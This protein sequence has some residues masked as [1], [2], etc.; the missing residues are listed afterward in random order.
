MTST[1]TPRERLKLTL[2]HQQPDRPPRRIVMTPEVRE[3]LED[4]FDERLGTRDVLAV[5]DVDFREVMPTPDRDRLRQH[6]AMRRCGPAADGFYQ[7]TH[8]RPL[9]HIQTL[10]DVEAYLPIRTPDWYD[11]SGIGETCRRFQAEG[12][13]AVFGNAGITDIVNG[14][15]ARGRGYEQLICEIMAEDAVAVALIDKHLDADYEYCRRALEAAGGGI[16]V[17]YIGE[18]CGTQNG[19]LFSPERFR[20]FFVPRMKPFADLAH[21]HGAACMLHSCGS[22]RQLMPMFIEEIGIDILDAV[23]PEPVGMDP[24]GLKR[25][26]GDRITFSGMLSLQQTLAHGTEDDCRRE[27]EHRIRVI[28]ENGGYIFGP[29]NSITL[30]TP[31]GNVLAV[32]EVATGKD[33]G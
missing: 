24:E 5:L 31:L 14:L 29:P 7:D 20:D 3:R 32:Y 9:A 16:D 1:M 25:D 18:D 30:D 6:P 13:V 27:A 2:S 17:L 12:F 28:G 22:T 15:G 23:Q 11:F 19:P 8:T 33:L 21:Q 4:H 10:D 26:F